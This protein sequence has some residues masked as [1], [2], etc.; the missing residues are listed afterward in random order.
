MFTNTVW[1]SKPHRSFIQICQLQVSSHACLLMANCT[2]YER[3]R[4]CSLTSTHHRA[5]SRKLKPVSEDTVCSGLDPLSVRRTFL[6]R[7]HLWIPTDIC[8]PLTVSSGL[9]GCKSSICQ[10]HF[11][12]SQAQTEKWLGTQTFTQYIQYILYVCMCTYTH[13][14]A[15]GSL[16][17][18][19]WNWR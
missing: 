12:Q 17:S 13:T 9:W 1:I 14:Q 7:S 6:S 15:S 16:I 8:C 5:T 3:E 19:T 2:T 11:S 18:L 10:G 4:R